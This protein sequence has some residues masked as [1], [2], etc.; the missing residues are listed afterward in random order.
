MTESE[1]GPGIIKEAEIAKCNKTM[2]KYIVSCRDSV[3]N[4]KT[5]KYLLSKISGSQQEKDLSAPPNCNGFGRIK[6]F[7]RNVEDWRPDFLQ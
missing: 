1:P 6:H 3:F 4:A 5:R 2:E 7:K